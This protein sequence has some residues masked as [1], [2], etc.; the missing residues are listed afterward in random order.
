MSQQLQTFLDEWMPVQIRT[1]R[2][3]HSGDAAPWVDV[4]SHTEPVSV[5]GAGIRGRHGW[6]EVSRT[7]NWVA[8]AFEDCQSYDYDLVVADARGDLAYTCGFER[9]TALRPNGE[10][11]HNELRVT[12]IYRRENGVWRIAHRHGDHALTQDPVS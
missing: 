1:G 2:A 12:Q 6:P 5:F 3:V 7:V 9:Y 10:E 4:W 8:T 11:V